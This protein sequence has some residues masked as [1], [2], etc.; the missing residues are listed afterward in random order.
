M[1]QYIMIEQHKMLLGGLCRLKS[2]NPK[3]PIIYTSYNNA[4]RLFEAKNNDLIACVVKAKSGVSLPKLSE[5]IE[6]MLG[7]NTKLHSIALA[8]SAHLANTPSCNNLCNLSLS[9]IIGC[10]F[11]ILTIAM[12]FFDLDKKIFAIRFLGAPFIV[13]ITIFSLQGI[14]SFTSSW[15]LAFFTILSSQFI[16]QTMVPYFSINVIHYLTIFLSTFLVVI[17]VIIYR[18][19]KMAGRRYVSYRM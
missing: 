13:F 10:L 12:I 17:G 3:I 1:G 9:L 18:L 5:K 11:Y 15:L 6:L 7:L 4:I 2:S 8:D 14:V 16:C 19:F